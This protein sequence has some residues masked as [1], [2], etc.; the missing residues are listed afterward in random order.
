MESAP[1][2]FMHDATGR[3]IEYGDIVY[4]QT[5]D[6]PS[7]FGPHELKFLGPCNGRIGDPAGRFRHTHNPD[8]NTWVVYWHSEIWPTPELAVTHAIRKLQDKINSLQ[9]ALWM[10]GCKAAGRK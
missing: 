5:A 2:V 7:I 8:E 3:R 9:Q 4:H 1:K 10:P 6:Y